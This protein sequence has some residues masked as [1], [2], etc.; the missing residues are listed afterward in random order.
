MITSTSLK[1][2][3]FMAKVVG[4]CDRAMHDAYVRSAGALGVATVS[5]AK[6]KPSMT[7]VFRAGHGMEFIDSADNDVTSVVVSAL[8][9]LHGYKAFH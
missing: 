2:I 3:S 6:G 9:E 1:S 4:A 5:N 8:R 7:A